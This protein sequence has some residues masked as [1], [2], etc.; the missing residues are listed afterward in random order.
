MATGKITKRSVDAAVTGFL[1]DEELRGFGLKVTSAGAR[2]Y[3]FQYRM[4]GRETT[5]RR[6]TIGTHGSPWTPT[7]ARQ[8]AERLSMLVKRGVDPREQEREQRRQAVDLAFRQYA[9]RFLDRY[10]RPEWPASYDFAES[11]LRLHVVPIL[12]DKP[13]P[14]INRSDVAELL[15]RLA[16]ERPALRRNVY[17]VVRRLF[18]WA[19]GRGDIERSPLEG[20]ET[21]AGVASRDRVLSDEELALVWEASEQLEYPFG[22]LFRLLIVTGQRREEVAALEWNELD[23]A[24]RAWT[25]PAARSKSG[26]AHI[27]P[28]SALAITALDLVARSEAW[29]RRGY[30]FTTTGK[31]PVSG[32]SRAK[33]RLDGA[34]AA[35]SAVAAERSTC[36]G[37]EPPMAPWRVHDLRRTLATGFQRLGVR[38]EVTEAV[39]N[40]VSGARSGVA[41]VYQRHDWATEKRTALDAWSKHIEGLSGTAQRTNVIPLAAA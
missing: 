22:P 4:G 7:T 1:W 18:R 19:A 36:P 2:S 39:L 16:I 3:V 14:L 38:F 26:K 6:F 10:V 23:R 27:I 9:S 8:E 31:T 13:L 41:G 33:R 12:A 24:S 21:P 20:F 37:D 5:A 11:I 25:L 35:C 30:V 29:P 15:D 34:I 17:A 32:Y 40:H 28:L